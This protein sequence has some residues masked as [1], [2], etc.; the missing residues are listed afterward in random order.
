M[1]NRGTVDLSR[2][3]IQRC[4]TGISAMHV[5]ERGSARILEQSTDSIFLCD[6]ISGAH[7]L[8]S[9]DPQSGKEWI[10]AHEKNETYKLFLCSCKENAIF[11]ANRYGIPRFMECFQAVYFKDE[12][13]KIQSELR[14]RAAHPKDYPLIRSAYDMLGEAEIKKIISQRKLLIGETGDTPVG[15]IG[16][17]LDGSM[18]MLTV[19]PEFRGRGYGA[20]LERYLIS[21][22]IERGDVPHCQ[23][24]TDNNTS[25]RLQEKLGLWIS[26]E[27]LFWVY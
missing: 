2:N 20:D 5:I 4:S 9:S 21:M 24:Q 25:I 11:A 6:T 7:M 1:S 19:F 26:S 23:V 18:G 14:V 27:K 16:E 3:Q 8:F 15:F 22:M 17:H 13:P 10:C 12:D